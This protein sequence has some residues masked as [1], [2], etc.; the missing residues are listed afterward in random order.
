MREFLQAKLAIPE[1]AEQVS[2]LPQGF[3]AA[4]TAISK[5]IPQT[6][7][8]GD[9]VRVVG[10]VSH[11]EVVAAQW[12]A[13][14]ADDDKT[15]CCI[16][17]AWFYE[18]LSRWVEAE[19]C[20]QRALEIS[21]TALGD[22]HPDTASSL[23]NLAGL[24]SSQGRYG[25]AEPLYVEALEIRKTALGDR[26]PDTASS[27]FNLAAFYYNTQRHQQA[28]AYIEQALQIYIPTLGNDHP[29]TQAA[30]SWYQGIQQAITNQQS[31]S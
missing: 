29:T 24:Y 19:R 5:T 13:V 18:S 23:N 15:W 16:G 9:R 20:C 25:E 30:N 12:T 7:T 31:P 2:T 4:M 8:L 14:L 27:L 26:H 1:W 11:L 22:R 10:A 6:P 3:A 17:L 21:K 28:L